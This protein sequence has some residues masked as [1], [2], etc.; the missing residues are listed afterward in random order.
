MAKLGKIVKLDDESSGSCVY[1]GCDN[2]AFPWGTDD[3]DGYVDVC[4]AH[5]KDAIEKLRHERIDEEPRGAWEIHASV[6]SYGDDRYG[7]D[8]EDD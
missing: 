4:T 5:A 1:R 8:G 6:M 3:I 2:E 7:G